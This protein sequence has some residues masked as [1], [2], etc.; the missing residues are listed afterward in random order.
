MNLEERVFCA[1]KRKVKERINCD[2]TTKIV[3]KPVRRMKKILK[4]NLNKNYK[5]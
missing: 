1:Y 3:F 5:V 2:I 4:L